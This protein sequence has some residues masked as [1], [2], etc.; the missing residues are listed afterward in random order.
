MKRRQNNANEAML[1]RLSALPCP[2]FV[3]TAEFDSGPALGL[4]LAAVHCTG[5]VLH[6]VHAEF[7]SHIKRSRCV[8]HLECSWL[9]AHKACTV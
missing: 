9:F 2:S 6:H 1:W 8:N 4:D 3:S 5:A 7:H